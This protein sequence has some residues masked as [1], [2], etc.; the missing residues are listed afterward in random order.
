[1]EENHPFLYKVISL[2]DGW[3]YDINK[4]RQ[5]ECIH[6]LCM[7]IF[8]WPTIEYSL[9]CKF[10]VPKGMCKPHYGNGAPAMFTS[11]CFP[12]KR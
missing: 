6:I 10:K 9:V 8:V 4:N 12:A 5:C 11:E 3:I 2:E 7:P 1:M